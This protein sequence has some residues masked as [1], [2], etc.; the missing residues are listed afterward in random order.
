M[1][2]SNTLSCQTSVE[3]AF[4]PSYTNSKISAEADLRRLLTPHWAATGGYKLEVNR[5]DDLEVSDAEAAE[6]DSTG[7]EYFISSLNLGISRDTS[8]NVLSPTSGATMTASIESATAALGSEVDFFKPDLELVGY[9]PLRPKWVA[10]GRIR[11]QTI[12]ET[13]DTVDIPIY[14]RLFLGGSNTVRG[15]AYQELSPMDEE[16]TPLGGLSALSGNLE[17]R[18]PLY[19]KLAGVV[20]LDAG[21]VGTESFGADLDDLR[22]TCGAGLRYHTL[23]GPLRIDWGYKLNRPDRDDLGLTDRPQDPVGDRWRLHFSI[24]QAF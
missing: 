17:L 13:E 18:F 2:R 22:F 14:K 21:L 12:Q 5:L 9:L 3:Q 24:G 1:S 8:D 4:Q 16:E 15:Y 20:F 11:L 19:K 7:E 10:A 6:V 23:V